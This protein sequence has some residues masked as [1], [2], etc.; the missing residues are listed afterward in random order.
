VFEFTIEQIELRAI[1]L[2]PDL[3]HDGACEQ[4]NRGNAP[5]A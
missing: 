3:F 1:D 5:N 4:V 2:Q